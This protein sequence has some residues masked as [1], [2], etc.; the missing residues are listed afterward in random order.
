MKA[1]EFHRTLQ[2]HVKISWVLHN[3]VK[4]CGNFQKFFKILVDFVEFWEIC[5]KLLN[6]VDFFW[7]KTNQIKKLG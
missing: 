3:F 5:G 7:N 6:S 4:F 2:K 1:T